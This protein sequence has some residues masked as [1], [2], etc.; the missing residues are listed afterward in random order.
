MSNNLELVLR[1][2]SHSLPAAVLQ[3]DG[4]RI[5]IMHN[6]TSPEDIRDLLI[7]YLYWIQDCI[8]EG[9]Q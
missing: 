8:N 3:S 9:D 6:G 7:K 2:N 1:E 4:D 5:S